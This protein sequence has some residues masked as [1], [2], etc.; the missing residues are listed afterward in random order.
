MVYVGF[1]LFFLKVFGRE[2][3]VYSH[4]H[5]GTRARGTQDGVARSAVRVPRPLGSPP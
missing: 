5:E 4:C 2:R 1:S 3:S